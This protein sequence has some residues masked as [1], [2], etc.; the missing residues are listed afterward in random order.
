[1]MAISKKLSVKAKVQLLRPEQKHDRFWL[2]SRGMTRTYLQTFED[3]ELILNFAKELDIIGDINACLNQ[4]RTRLYIESIEDCTLLEF[5]F[6]QVSNKFQHESWWQKII[7][8]Y[9]QKIY[10]EREEHLILLHHH[11]PKMRVM[12]LYKTNRALF[13]RVPQRHL[14]NYLGMTDVSFS[15]IKKQLGILNSHS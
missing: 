3:K 15:R 6:A 7:S 5:S 4:T 12:E 14:A 1:M 8:T 11:S 2:V 10:L 9:L 13:R